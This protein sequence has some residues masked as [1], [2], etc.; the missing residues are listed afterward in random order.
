M[1]A[2]F[3][4]S[5]VIELAES[6]LSTLPQAESCYQRKK[7]SEFACLKRKKERTISQEPP[8]RK[9]VV[10]VSAQ[11]DVIEHPDCEHLAALFEAARYF[12]VLL[13]RRGISGRM[14]VHTDYGGRAQTKCC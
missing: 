11:N 5:P 2:S 14:I 7:A 1:S 6:Y 3:F 8:I 9:A 10:A 12:L 4:D 13:A